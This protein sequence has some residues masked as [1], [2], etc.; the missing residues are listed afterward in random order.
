M[1]VFSTN[2]VRHLYVAKVVKDPKV[3]ATDEAGSI[4]LV[5]SDAGLYFQYK[6][7]DNLMRS[8]LIDVKNV[9]SVK[10][11]KADSMQHKLKAIKV[12]LDE[13]VNGGAPIAGQDYILRIAFR[14]FVGMSDEDVYFKYGM[15]HAYAGMDAST[16]YKKLALSL[17]KNFSRELSPMVKFYL[18]TTEVTP[19]TKESELT[20]TYDGVVIEEVEQEWNLGIK[21]QVP[22]YF[23]VYPTTVT[24]EGDEVLWGKTEEVTASPHNK[25]VNNGKTIADLEYFC[26]GER[27]DVYRNVGWPNSIPTKYLVDP[28]LPY[29]T[30]DIHYAFVDSN[31]SVQK[32][33]KDIT[34]VSSDM[35]VI[36]DLI[37]KLN[38]ATGLTIEELA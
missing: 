23:E 9:L 20:S 25:V 10:A 8:D 4:A 31:E 37:E 21:P 5:N 30:L 27:G 32:S 13:E 15:V 12:S 24:Y 16:F 14:Q 29:H 28:T 6:G 38:T 26:M 22:V 11:A 19:T 36:N 3:L 2:Q 35:E 1:A 7:A 17:A 18:G 33:E 34:I